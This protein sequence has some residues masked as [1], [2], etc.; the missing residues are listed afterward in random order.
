[1]KNN[2]LLYVVTFLVAVAL[3]AGVLAFYHIDFFNMKVHIDI[4]QHRKACI[5]YSAD[6]IALPLDHSSE[7]H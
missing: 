3:G 6:H 1:M 5:D 2:K 4:N 7:H